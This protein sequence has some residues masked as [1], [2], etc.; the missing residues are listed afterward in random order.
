MSY[1]FLLACAL[2]SDGAA[3]DFSFPLFN[4]TASLVFNGDAATS[5][6][7]DG[8]AYLY[9]TLAVGSERADDEY[10]EAGPVVASSGSATRSVAW[11]RTLQTGDVASPSDPAR[12][13][14]GSRDAFAPSPD[15]LRSPCAVRARLT[16][17]RPFK[18]G[19]VTHALPVRPLDGWESGFTFQITDAS[20]H[21]TAVKDV[22]FGIASHRTCSVAGGDGLAWVLHGDMNESMALGSGGGHLGYGGLRNALA[23]EFDSWFNAGGAEWDDADIPFDHVSVQASPPGGPEEG[24]GVRAVTADA[25]TRI[26]G[27]PLRVDVADGLVHAVRIAYY[28]YV[29]Y[30]FLERFV[31]SDAGLAFL[32]TEGDARPV[33]TLAVWVDA[34]ASASSCGAGACAGESPR[35]AQNTTTLLPTLAIPINLHRLLRA[36]TGAAWVGLTAATGSTAWQKHDVLSWYWCDRVGCPLSNGAPERTLWEPNAT[37]P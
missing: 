9:S 32:T 15:T 20:R 23:V 26:S 37:T 1:L 16:P 19:G 34:A 12:G 6:C 8:G 35:A 21:C 31:G 7:D 3:G 11:T 17:S 10:G 2:L 29:K 18:V 24:V 33:G 13:A 25:R 4:D 22:A 14:F 5:A 27:A 30:D 28:P 36:P